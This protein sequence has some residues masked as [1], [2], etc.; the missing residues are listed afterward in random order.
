MNIQTDQAMYFENEESSTIRKQTF[1]KDT[2]TNSEA[3]EIRIPYTADSGTRD[4]K[5]YLNDEV[6]IMETGYSS[7]RKVDTERDLFSGHPHNSDQIIVYSG[8]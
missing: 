7:S 8:I 4:N 1:G 2:A 3:Q 6:R 5:A